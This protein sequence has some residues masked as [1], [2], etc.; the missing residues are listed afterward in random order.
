MSRSFGNFLARKQNQEFTYRFSKLCESIARSGMRWDDYCRYQLYPTLAEGNYQSPDE[1]LGLLNEVQRER[2]RW[3]P[4]RLFGSKTYDDGKPDPNAVPEAPSDKNGKYNWR[5]LG[6]T[7]V[8][9][10]SKAGPE[11]RKRRQ[12]QFDA[13][14]NGTP[15]PDIYGPSTTDEDPNAPDAS[16][17]DINDPAVAAGEPPVQPPAAAAKKKGGI[18]QERLDQETKL[19][20]A[21]GQ[22]IQ[23]RFKQ[24]LQQFYDMVRDDAHSTNNPHQYEVLRYFMKKIEP[25]YQQALTGLKAKASKGNEMRQIFTGPSRQ[26][27]EQRQKAARG[28]DAGIHHADGPDGSSNSVIAPTGDDGSVISTGLNRNGDNNLGPDSSN[29][30][31]TS[32]PYA[33]MGSVSSTDA[34][35]GDLPPGFGPFT[36]GDG[37]QQPEAPPE[38]PVPAPAPTPVGSVVSPDAQQ[39][40][41]AQSG[42]YVKPDDNSW[43]EEDVNNDIYYA[44]KGDGGGDEEVKKILADMR[45]QGKS[46]E[47]I[48]HAVA[49]YR[50]KQRKSDLMNATHGSDDER[51]IADESYHPYKKLKYRR[52]R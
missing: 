52:Y 38:A 33:G 16:V 31:D 51:S 30:S 10:M 8:D 14:K 42:G 28:P 4:M 22:N 36:A 7:S 47:E 29:Q 50:A 46:K 39:A 23:G 11:D 12:A 21:A 48:H 34:G 9:Q 17:P 49:A 26:S 20:Q 18:S 35:M 45:K 43:P 6:Y 25:A 41:A 37:V 19:Y 32:N 1:L 40:V 44:D 3:S 5:D 13:K 15:Q 2:H 24:A 27:Y